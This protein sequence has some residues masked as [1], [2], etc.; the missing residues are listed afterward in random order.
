[1]SPCKNPNCCRNK[2]NCEPKPREELSIPAVVDIASRIVQQLTALTKVGIKF[3]PEEISVAQLTSTLQ[4]LMLENDTLRKLLERFGPPTINV[5]ATSAA[6]VFG[7]QQNYVLQL[8]VGSTH[9]RE[10]LAAQF[11][12]AADQLVGP[13]EY[14][15]GKA[16]FLPAQ[17]Q[18]PFTN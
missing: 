9:E 18:L 17:Q 8:A 11:R 6:I 4:A 5:D 1:M 12:A 10:L 13:Q 16:Q 14:S 3:L 7:P 2:S 15:A